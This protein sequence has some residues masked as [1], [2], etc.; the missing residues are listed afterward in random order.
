[1]RIKEY[2]HSTYGFWLVLW[3]V[4]LAGLIVLQYGFGFA[5]RFA[6]PA[7]LARGAPNRHANPAADLRNHRKAPAAAVVPIRIGNKNS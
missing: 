3:P 1:M 7:L 5:P 2:V 4:F 6:N